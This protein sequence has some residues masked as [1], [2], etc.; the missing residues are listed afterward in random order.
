MV[1]ELSVEAGILVSGCAKPLT[2]GESFDE[3]F[4]LK[5]RS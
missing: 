1:A 3:R 2:T 4:L 5:D